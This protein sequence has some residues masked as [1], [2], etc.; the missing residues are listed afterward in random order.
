V[1]EAFKQADG[2]ISRSYGGTG[3]GLS[4]SRQLALGLQGQLT[5]LSQPGEGST[6]TLLL[7]VQPET[8]ALPLDTEPAATACAQQD[9]VAAPAGPHGRQILVVEDDLNFQGVLLERCQQ[10]GLATLSAA[11]GESALALARQ[12]VPAAI[13]LDVMMPKL[14]GWEVMRHLQSDLATAQIPVHFIT[15]LDERSRA[16]ELGAASFATKPITL[17][18]LDALLERVEQSMAAT[19]ARVLIVEDNAAEAYALSELLSGPGVQTEVASSGQQALACLQREKFDALV[20]DLGLGDIKGEDLLRQIRVDHPA[21]QLPVLVHSGRNPDRGLERSL[22]HLAQVLIVKGEYSPARVRQEVH[23]L[24]GARNSAAA[25]QAQTESPAASNSA[26]PNLK[27]RTVLMADDDMRNIF[28]IG[29][30]LGYHGVNLIEAENGREALELLAANPQI[31][32]ILMDI[33]MPEMDGYTAIRAIRADA[34]HPAQAQLP[35]IAMTAKTMP[36]DRELCLAAGANDY[37]AKPLDNEKLLSM[38]QVWLGVPQ[39][40]AVGAGQDAGR[41][42]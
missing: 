21:D 2:G 42:A 39:S 23:T 32:L 3:L 14:N 22:S 33:M 35:I 27:G 4:I 38:L 29:S 18:Q 16:F 40:S 25:M 6:F 24:L 12:H 11:D 34:L 15:A 28:A 31:E 5:L 36:G 17:A 13:L 37:I 8:A 10:R 19:P 7:P 26:L 41:D 1:F 30:L 20:L 9:I